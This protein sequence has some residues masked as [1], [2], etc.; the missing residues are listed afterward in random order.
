MQPEDQG[1]CQPGKTLTKKRTPPHATLL[2]LNLVRITRRRRGRHCLCRSWPRRSSS[3]R[4]HRGRRRQRSR[5]G[6]ERGFRSMEKPK[7][8]VCPRCWSGDSIGWIHPKRPPQSCRGRGRQQH[9]PQGLMARYL[10][11][12]A[13]FWH[14]L[15]CLAMALHHPSLPVTPSSR[16]AAFV[17]PPPWLAHRRSPPFG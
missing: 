4:G 16:L 3:R 14:L 5:L 7:A 11:W 13:S 10:G 15:G 12:T 6:L 17:P 8:R 9:L 1:F 2:D